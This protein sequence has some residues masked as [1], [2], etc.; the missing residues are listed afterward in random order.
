MKSPR[1]LVLSS[2][3]WLAHQL[4]PLADAKNWLLED[5]R[6]PGAVRT[7]LTDPRVQVVLVHLTL[8]DPPEGVQQLLHELTQ[9]TNPIPWCVAIDTKLSDGDRAA[10]TAALMDLGA[11]LV[12]F[13]PWT[14]PIVSSTI[15]GMM[16]SQISR[17]TGDKPIDLARELRDES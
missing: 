6:Q 10:W 1:I 17:Q 2:E 8:P 5:H 11:T 4:G 7:R 13:P 14:Q 15:Q 3:P 9:R 16:E 12:L